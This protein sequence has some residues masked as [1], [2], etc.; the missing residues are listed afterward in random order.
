MSWQQHKQHKQQL[1]RTNSS[2]MV[3]SFSFGSN[4]FI[5]FGIETVSV[6]NGAIHCQ[7]VLLLVATGFG[8]FVLVPEQASTTSDMQSR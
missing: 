6:R 2:T 7:Y 8:S 1:S 4:R 5:L 3:D